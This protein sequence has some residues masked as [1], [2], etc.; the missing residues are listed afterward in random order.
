MDSTLISRNVCESMFYGSVK[1]TLDTG[2]G[3]EI[4][5]TTQVRTFT[6]LED[7]VQKGKATFLE[8]GQ[9]LVEIRRRKLHKPKKWTQYLRERWGFSRQHAHRL[10]QA[11]ELAEMS[12]MGDKPQTEREARRRISDQRSKSRRPAPVVKDLEVEK[13]FVAFTK[14][15]QLWES[16]FSFEDYLTLVGKINRCTD[17]VLTEAGNLDDIVVS[18]QPELQEVPAV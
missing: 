17:D 18:E 2:S 4:N 13:E 15:L 16:E 3:P 5:Q 6:E 9:A 8:V 10:I 12:P 11:K 7:V 14:R 1:S